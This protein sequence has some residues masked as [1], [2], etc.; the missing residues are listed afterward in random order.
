MKYEISREVVT[1]AIVNAVAHRDYTSNGSVQ[2]MLFSD[3]LEVWNLGR[4]PSS[5]PLEKLRVAHGL[6]PGNPLLAESL[7][8]TNYIE[9][10][11]TGTRDM[12]RRYVAAELPAPEFAVTDGFVATVRRKVA[13][14][15]EKYQGAKY[16][17]QVTGE[18]TGEVAGEVT[19]EVCRLLQV[20]K[21]VPLTRI[22][23][24]AALRIK[25]QANFRD[26]YLGP[27]LEAGLIEMTILDKPRSRNQKYRIKE[28]GTGKTYVYLRTIYEL[29]QQYGFKKFIIVV[30]SVAIREGVD[31]FEK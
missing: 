29:R 3:R 23:A 8:L 18:G 22:E 2:V 21:K 5:L 20:L 12:I 15:S 9:R 4:L 17:G 30:P 14:V 27:A 28:T 10:M 16:T 11:G 26:R 25:G 13:L 31:L 19:G 7:Y 1:E 6:V 24:Q